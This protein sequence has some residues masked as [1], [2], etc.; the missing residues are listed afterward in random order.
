MCTI[1]AVQL[2]ITHSSEMAQPE[3]SGVAKSRVQPMDR[4]AV[5]E[6]V[7]PNFLWEDPRPSCES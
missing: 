1:S 7:N 6:G 5:E 4:R 2:P 3:Q